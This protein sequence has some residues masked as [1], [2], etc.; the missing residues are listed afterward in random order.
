M[1]IGFENVL[2][3]VFPVLQRMDVLW[4]AGHVIPLQRHFA[5]ALIVK[6]DA[7]SY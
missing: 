6:K 7:G 1:Y 4:L 5:R 3:V 2:Q